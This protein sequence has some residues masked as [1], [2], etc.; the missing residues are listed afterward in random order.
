M[1]PPELPPATKTCFVS[2]QYLAKMSAFTA[3]KKATLVFEAR[4]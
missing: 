1:S 4:S 3:L 2:T